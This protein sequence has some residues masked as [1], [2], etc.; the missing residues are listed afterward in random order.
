MFQK[1][2]DGILKI[3]LGDAYDEKKDQYDLYITSCISRESVLNKMYKDFKKLKI[4]VNIDAVDEGDD[5]KSPKDVCA[6]RGFDEYFTQENIHEWIKDN[7]LERFPDLIKK[8]S[9]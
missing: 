9:Y 2:L 1:K 3:I 5:F 7:F 8:G 6:E 4:E